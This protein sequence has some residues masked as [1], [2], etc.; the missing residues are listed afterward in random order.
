MR[1]GAHR[2]TDTDRASGEGG[3]TIIEM[4]VALVILAI[5]L[6]PLARVYWSS[7]RTAGAATHR[8]DGSS[9]ASREIESMHAVPYAQV[10]FYADQPGYVST[11]EG[12]TTVSLGSTSP[13]SGPLVPQ[14]DTQ[15]TGITQGSVDYSVSR[16]IVWE[17]ADDAS[18]TY[19]SAYKRLTV[20]VSWSD[21]AGAHTARQD[22]L[23]YPGGLGAYQAPM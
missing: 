8:T 1:P 7:I 17:N 9:I 18:T 6:A 13:T 4:V 14:I 22:S 19:A 20:I 16:Y 15:T 11:F 10:G 5:V 23:L 3:F 2:H 12:L 21:Q